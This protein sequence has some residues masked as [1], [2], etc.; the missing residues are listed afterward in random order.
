MLGSV[1][2]LGQVTGPQHLHL[3]PAV[4]GA[5]REPAAGVR[6]HSSARTW[7]GLVLLAV[8][9]VAARAPGS[10]LMCFL[11][12]LVL[13]FWRH[14]ERALSNQLRSRTLRSYPVL[15]RCYTRRCHSPCD[16]RGGGQAP[17]SQTGKLRHRAAN[18]L[19]H[20]P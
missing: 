16:W 5:Q 3:Q 12:S 17:I 9:T 10:Q 6:R 13:C 20:S 15:G 19:A 14:I 2:S 4:T 11:S 1:T 7:L 18:G 8:L